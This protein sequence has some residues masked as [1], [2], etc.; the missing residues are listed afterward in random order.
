M[1][2]GVS[3][4]QLRSIC[5]WACP[6]GAPEK[7]LRAIAQLPAAGPT[8]PRTARGRGGA[9]ACAVSDVAEDGEWFAAADAPLRWTD[10]GLAG[11]ARDQGDAAVLLGAFRRRGVD[12]L[13]VLRGHY[14]L[15]IVRADGREAL[16]AVDRLGTRPLAYALTPQGLIFA[17]DAATLRRHPGVDAALDPQALYD[18]FYFNVVP[19]PLGI[20]AGQRKL[21]PAQYLHYRD[22]RFTVGYHWVPRFA[23]HSRADVA[24]M[25]DALRRDLRAA[26]R[27]ALPPSGAGAFLS[28]G[29]DS[30]TVCGVL[31]EV[32]RS[33]ARS[34]SIGFEVP[35]YDEIR[36][37][38][39]AARRFG[40]EAHEYYVTPRDV[41]EGISLIAREYDEPFGNSSALP[42]Y[43]CARLAKRHG[44][45][46]LLAGDGGDEL[47]AGNER[48]VKQQ[49]FEMYCGL[50]QL[51]R[52]WLIDPLAFGVP[53]GTRI[54]PLRKLRRY[55]EQAR[56]PLPRRLETYNLLH[57][58]PLA[59][60]FTPEFLR[61]V[62]PEH[63][64][65]S[66]RANF[67]RCHA[68]SV[69]DRMLYLDWKFTLADNDLRKVSQMCAAAGVAVRYPMLDD[70]LIELSTR[71]P[72]GLKMRPYRLR[73]FFKR[74]MRDFLPPEIIA[75][76]KHGFGLPFGEWLRTVPELRETAYAAVRAHARRG[77]VRADFIDRI[78]RAHQT[79]H[80]GFYGS[81]IWAIMMLELWLQAHDASEAQATSAVGAR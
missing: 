28:G 46:V 18:Y 44:I 81:A 12:A 52:R 60:I 10:A 2:T 15:A 69:L 64:I 55:V 27:R 6:E 54:A 50:P 29:I 71:I 41:V 77:Y 74:A 3:G 7:F 32:D 49:M 5:G 47:F 21:E 14:A 1:L 39:I 11:R 76:R 40:L 37:A 80:A 36:Y 13:Q 38:R 33:Q 53:G 17:S 65:E 19:S 78:I 22:G 75:K 43:Y 42:V 20:R 9:L 63:P 70:D 31:A 23:A 61:V 45:D 26:V 59:E 79:E 4:P 8:A 56:V 58:L 30:S 57:M 72:P 73:H 68:S 24:T 16:L 51:L 35:G 25:A 66:M 34:F 48:Y 62:D 67:D